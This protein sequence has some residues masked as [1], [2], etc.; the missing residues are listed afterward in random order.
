[1]IGRFALIL[2]VLLVSCLSCVAQTAALNPQKTETFRLEPD[3]TKEFSIRLRKNGFANIEWLAAHDALIAIELV[4]SQGSV[5]E[6]VSTDDWNSDA[7][8]F[9]APFEGTYL[10]RIKLKRSETSI[11]PQSIS[12][13]YSD[14]FVRPSA[15]RLK[16]SRVIN[17]YQVRIL[18]TKDDNYVLFEKGS[19]LKRVMRASGGADY[20]GFSFPDKLVPKMTPKARAQ[21]M[22]LRDTPDKTGDGV[23]DVMVEYFSGGAHCCFQEYFI[24]LGETAD[25]VDHINTAHSGMGPLAKNPSGGLVFETSDNSW[26]YWPQ[27]FATSPFPS[28]VLVFKRNKLTP[29]FARMKKPPPSLAVLRQMA[30]KAR[31]QIGLAPYYGDDSDQPSPL[32]NDYAKDLSGP[33]YSV[34]LDLI[35]SGNEGIAW[36]FFDLVW[37]LE[38]KGKDIFRR[39]FQKKLS[40]SIYSTRSVPRPTTL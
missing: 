29:D 15:A 26:A 36:Q 39:D 8:Y 3:E 14:R 10:L 19:V 1:M 38:K 30:F 24:N 16:E 25:V 27:G 37:P 12:V 21:A 4:D 9:V 32:F 31:N 17:G 22:L 18:A 34:M 23:P 35:Y 11:H 28:V 5:L 6:R 2:T 13:E 33:F 20:I 40:E 7:L